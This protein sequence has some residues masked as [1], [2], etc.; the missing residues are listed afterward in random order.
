MQRIALAWME[1]RER[2]A[3]C[4]GGILAD[5]QVFSMANLD[6]FIQDFFENFLAKLR[7]TKSVSWLS[8]VYQTNAL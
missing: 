7:A 6:L 8:F 2:G 1:K 4:A 5:D 3:E